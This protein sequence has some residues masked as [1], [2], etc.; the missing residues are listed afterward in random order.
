MR[1]QPTALAALALVIASPFA[2]LADDCAPR[3]AD[4]VV[5]DA[6]ERV[7]VAGHME[8]RETRHVLPA[9][10][11]EELVPERREVVVIPAVTREVVVPAVVE[12]VYVPAVVQRV[13]V[14]EVRER[15]LVPGRFDVRIDRHGF[16]MR[17]WCAPHYE[18]RVV[19][20]GCYEDRCVTPAHYEDRVTCR[21]RREV[22]VIVPERRETRVVEP[23]RVRTVVVRPERVEVTVDHVWIPGHFETR[24]I[25]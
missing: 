10:T 4:V 18:D 1:I 2:A 14:G 15:V 25:R 3:A 23:A 9:V 11:R 20:E 5:A 6:C 21:E 19:R 22:R 16:E 7:W 13:Y 17:D 24:P 8:R 12:R